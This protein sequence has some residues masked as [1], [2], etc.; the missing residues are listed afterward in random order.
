MPSGQKQIVVIDLIRFLAAALVLAFHMDFIMTVPRY[1]SYQLSYGAI[2]TAWNARTSYYGW[3]GVEIFFVISGI[4]ICYS[5]RGATA[6]TFFRSRFLRLVPTAWVCATITLMLL[7]AHRGKGVGDFR[8]YLNTLVFW[9]FG[10]YIENAFW[11][12][13]VEVVFYGS[14][15]VLIWLGAI[16]RIGSL[17]YGLT[18]ISIAYWTVYGGLHLTNHG[19]F[20]DD[21][22][23]DRVA[24]LGMMQY[25]S[26]FALGIFISKAMI[27]RDWRPA[28][29]M[30][31]LACV[32][33]AAQIYWLNSFRSF[34]LLP[35][36]GVGPAFGVFALAMVV[37][38]VG[39]AGNEKLLR[40]RSLVGVLRVMGLMTYPLYLLH[41]SAGAILTYRLM[42]FGLNGHAARVGAILFAF[43][44]TYIVV[45]FLEPPV[46]RVFAKGLA[47][48]H[49]TSRPESTPPS[50]A[51]ERAPQPAVG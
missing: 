6:A 47:R 4:V 7:L 36:E 20:L 25:G 38:M 48:V 31:A 43:G 30:V 14:V 35:G 24:A 34:V 26:F 15:L 49:P 37:M 27:E 33:C 39:I 8:A 19:A 3:V 18:G 9:P 42:S 22:F 29:P 1:D 28:A 16:R 5:A 2:Q 40:Q 46:R 23:P 10:P 12:L 21:Y 32:G 41:Q 51:S 45:A 11:T 44:L 50:H 13:G 17:A